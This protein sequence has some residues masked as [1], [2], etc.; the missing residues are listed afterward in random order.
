MKHEKEGSEFR[1]IVCDR[2]WKDNLVEVI[3]DR[4]VYCHDSC[5]HVWL[6]MLKDG[7]VDRMIINSPL[8]CESPEQERAD[9]DRTGDSEV[10]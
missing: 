3:D 10:S 8:S 1:H 9:D 4:I 2:C 6:K 5:A 7:G